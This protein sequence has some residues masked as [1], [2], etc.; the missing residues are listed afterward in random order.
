MDDIFNSPSSAEADAAFWALADSALG[1]ADFA[2]SDGSTASVQPQPQRG[3]PFAPGYLP[4]A[5]QQPLTGPHAMHRGMATGNTTSYQPFPQRVMTPVTAYP[6]PAM[7]QPFAGSHPGMATGSTMAH[8]P[9]TQS[10]MAPAPFPPAAQQ[11]Q[12][13]LVGNG[14]QNTTVIAGNSFNYY[15]PMYQGMGIPAPPA[16]GQY[17]NGGYNRTPTSSGFVAPVSTTAPPLRDG[18]SHC[19]RAAGC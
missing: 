15:Q 18:R 3:M 5:T 2:A 1:G 12:Y 6:P 13:S 16:A 19:L 10:T 7:Q 8:Q 17:F 4:P 9:F 11:P 14:A